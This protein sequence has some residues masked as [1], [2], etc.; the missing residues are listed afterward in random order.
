M[1]ER[2][3][4]PGGSKVQQYIVNVL[5]TD[6]PTFKISK[7]KKRFFYQEGL[8]KW[9]NV[10][11]EHQF[12]LRKFSEYNNIDCVSHIDIGPKKTKNEVVV[13]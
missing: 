11:M 3:Q 5:S 4:W 7:R 6:M 2:D 12:S 9:L 8:N 1:R 10:V 13:L